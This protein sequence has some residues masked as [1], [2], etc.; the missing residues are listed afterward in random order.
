ML[1]AVEV[2]EPRGLSMPSMAFPY[3]NSLT[4][5]GVFLTAAHGANYGGQ[6]GNLVRAS[7]TGVRV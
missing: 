3:H 6:F 5:G 2:L 7:S 1:Q 4:V